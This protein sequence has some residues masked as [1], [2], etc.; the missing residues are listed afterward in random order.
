MLHSN[1]MAAEKPEYVVVEQLP[2]GARRVVLSKDATAVENEDGQSWVFDQ[3]DFCLEPDRKETKASI[4]ERFDSW[5]EHAVGYRQGSSA[6]T[7]EQRLEN[8]ENALLDMM[9]L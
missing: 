1:V 7:V 8:V 9:G 5:W 6:L 2:D 4:Q 3:A